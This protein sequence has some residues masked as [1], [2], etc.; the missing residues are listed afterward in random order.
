MYA[1]FARL[2]LMIGG[3]AGF[4]MALYGGV[5]K[6]FIFKV[7]NENMLDY[8]VDKKRLPWHAGLGVFIIT[9]SYDNS[10]DLT[11]GATFTESPAV[12]NYAIMLDFTW[13]K[14]FGSSRRFGFFVGAGFGPGNTKRKEPEWMWDVNVGLAIKLWQ[15]K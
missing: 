10:S 9:D 14:Y 8:Y 2:K 11:I 12:T 6:E 4:G 5:G 15:H 1:E 13:S 3:G 7:K